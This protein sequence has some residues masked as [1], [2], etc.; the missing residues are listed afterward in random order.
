[1]G[2]SLRQ[3]NKPQ[4]PDRVGISLRMVVAMLLILTLAGT[5][6][7][8]SSVR[9]LNIS[10]E[11]SKMLNMQHELMETG[12]RLKLELSNLRS[13]YTLERK[14]SSMGLVKPEANQIRRIN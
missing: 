3:K 2:F 6:Y 1:M 4:T 8:Y 11:T 5:F 9:A 7:A 12:R 14:A 10:Y 13:P